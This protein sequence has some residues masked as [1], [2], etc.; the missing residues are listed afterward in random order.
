M[1]AMQIAGRELE[2]NRKG[3]LARFDD[4]DR[5]V[6]QAMAEDEGLTLTDCHWSVIG[7]LRDY[8]ATHEIPPSPRVVVKT[9]GQEISAHVPCTRKHLDAL[10]PKGGCKQACR[11]AG[12]PNYYCHAC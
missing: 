5:D 11:I 6:A 12:L 10:F 7:F 4:W 8:Y 9:I 2:L 1:S 3:H